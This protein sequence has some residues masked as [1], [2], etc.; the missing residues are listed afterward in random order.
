MKEI[1]DVVI[2]GGGTAGSVVARRLID[3]GLSVLLLEAGSR[4]INP[5]IHEPNRMGQLRNGHDDWAYATVPQVH[6]ASRR[7]SLPRGKVLGGSHALNAM[8]WVRGAPADFDG[9]AADGNAGW[10]WDD[11]LPIYR[12]VESFSRGASDLHG[13]T[14]LMDVV[15]DYELHPI[16]RA[17]LD[18]A[19]QIGIPV[20]PDY[21]GE[22]QDGVS[23]QQLTMRAGKRLTTY[24]AYLHPVLNSPSLQVQTGAH[25]HRLLVE[26]GQV[27]GVEYE[28][29]GIIQQ[30]S[31]AQTILTA[32]ALDSPA[33]LL[34]SGIGPADE[35]R[36]FG[37]D[38]VLDLPGVGRNLQDHAL[39]PVIFG[40][41]ETVPPI[42]EGM[43]STQVH[44]FSRTRPDLAAPDTQPL[45]F[46]HPLYDTWMHGPSS[47]FT[48]MAG[49]IRP[50]SRGSL[51]L[52]GADVT[53]PLRI[54][55]RFLAEKDDLAALA[56][57]VAQC[58]AIG[59]APA[60]A[61]EWGAQELY[62]GSYVEDEDTLHDYIRRTVASYHHQVGTCRMGSDQDAVVDATLR[63]HGLESLM[64]A[65]AS[66]MPTI[67]SGNTNAPTV[68]I[69]ERAASF[70]A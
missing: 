36:A 44:L 33:L 22:R 29:N 16:Q 26:H 59:T 10:A 8:I 50:Q 23:Q 35:L 60:L 47:A 63:L 53:A 31:A 1:V 48:I 18:A 45:C 57:S 43:S 49:L 12:D 55:P 38:V 15:A 70:V 9:W 3:S 64:V 28:R 69:A 61:R 21:N 2:V 54:D 30:V 66:V 6:A 46:T 19:A 68:L 58:R 25:V 24:R 32:G 52:S 67:T 40:T 56:D 5:A 4:D 42:P 27:V 7:I 34:R 14:G 11:V 65:D 17:V 51:K 13:A 39:V 41:H 37:I 20:N 62:P